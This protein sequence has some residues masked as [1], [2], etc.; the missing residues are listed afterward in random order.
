MQVIKPDVV[1]IATGAQ[2]RLPEVDVEGVDLVD[3][4]AVIQ[5]QASIGKNVVIADW[6]CDWS[7]LGVAELLAREGHSV[8]L[9]CGGSIAGESIQ[10]IVRDQWI[11]ELHRLG[12]EITNYARFFGGMDGNAYFQH[13]TSGEAIVAE[14][15]DTIVSCYAPRSN[16]ECDWIE[17]KA[18]EF[19]IYRIG[20]AIS[21]RTVEEAMLEGF[22]IAW[23][24]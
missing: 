18:G 21:P 7:G 4:W 17:P 5:G 22:Q 24:I 19:V 3:S 10:G 20:D 1:I 2:P 8:R 9:F 12:V 16:R 6:A 15:V 14:D 11:G 13:M 23:D